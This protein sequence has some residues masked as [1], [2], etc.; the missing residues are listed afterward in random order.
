M[1]SVCLCRQRQPLPSV[2][3]RAIKLRPI[4]LSGN[5]REQTLVNPTALTI[6][7]ARDLR[8]LRIL[9]SKEK[10]RWQRS[11]LIGSRYFTWPPA[12][13]SNHN[14]KKT[15]R[16]V[17][18]AKFRPIIRS[19]APDTDLLGHAEYVIACSQARRHCRHGVLR[20]LRCDWLVRPSGSPYIRQ[21][22]FSAKIVIV[23]R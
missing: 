1:S 16:T 9:K 18:C 11:A 2:W 21:L 3:Y 4:R 23:L 8:A 5:Q 10:A 7:T 15:C 22:P 12:R 20:L 14:Q 19:R 6:G 17:Q 13:P